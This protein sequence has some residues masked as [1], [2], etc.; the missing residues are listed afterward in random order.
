MFARGTE[1]DTAVL[2]EAYARTGALLMGNRMFDGGAESWGV[3]GF[4][5]QVRST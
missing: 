2:E 4:K 5:M 1:K 3:R